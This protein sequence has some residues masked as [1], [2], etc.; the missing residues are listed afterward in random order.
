MIL[1][2]NFDEF[3]QKYSNKMKKLNILVF[4]EMEK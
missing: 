2:K 4:L 1:E 3:I